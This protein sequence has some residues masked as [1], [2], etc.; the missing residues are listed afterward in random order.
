LTA[1]AALPVQVELTWINNAADEDGFVLERRTGAGPFLR[2]TTLML[3]ATAYTDTHV[4][5]NT[6]Y[7]YRVLAFNLAGTSAYSNEAV[8]TTLP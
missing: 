6:T 1:T 3:G 2:V 8:V 5:A 7:T 4:E